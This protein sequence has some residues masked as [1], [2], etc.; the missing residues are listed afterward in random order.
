MN[1]G[2]LTASLGVDTIGLMQAEKQFKAFEMKANSSLARV[3]ASLRTVGT[4][5]KKFGSSASLYLTAPLLLVGGAAFK[6]SMDFEE[7]MSKIIGLVGVSKTQVEAWK[8]DIIAM[9]PALGKSP[10]ELADAMFFITSAGLRG[11]QALDVLNMSAKASAAGLGETK[12]V[13]DLVTS[14]MNAYGSAALSATKATDILV[15][16]VKEGKAEAGALTASLGT[17]L[18]VSSAMGV[19]FDQV[20]AAVAAMTRTGTNA[21]TASMQLRQI[22]VS[23]LKPMDGAKTALLNMGTSASGLRKKLREDGLIATLM[24]LKDVT[25]KYGEEAMSKVFPNV[26]ALSGVLDLVGKNAE[27]TEKIFKSLANATGLGAEAFKEATDTDMFKYNQMMASLK[28]TM[29]SLGK[30]LSTTFVPI[31]QTVAKKAQE[32]TE[33]FQNLTSTQQALLGKVI[34]FAAALGPVSKILGFLIGNVMPMLLTGVAKLIPLIRTL[35]MAMA[36]NPILAFATAILVVGTALVVLNNRMSESERIQA[37]LNDVRQSAVNHITDQKVQVEQL[38]RV[39]KNEAITIERRKAAIKKINEISPEYLKNITLETINTVAATR[40]KD[41]YLQAILKEAKIK[42]HQTDI[43]DLQK[44]YYKEIEQGSAKALNAQQKFEKFGRKFSDELVARVT[45]GMVKMNAGEAYGTAQSKRNWEARSKFILNSMKAHQDAIDELENPTNYK[46]SMEDILN[47]KLFSMGILDEPFR[48]GGSID[49][50]IPDLG[51][52]IDPKL[53][54]IIKGVNEQLRVHHVLGQQ[55]I[56]DYSELAE[57]NNTYTQALSTLARA[58]YGAASEQMMKYRNSIKAVREETEKRKPST[59]YLNSLKDTVYVMQDY[60]K[61]LQNVQDKLHAQEELQKVFGD[62]YNTNAQKADIYRDAIKRLTTIYGAN[63]VQVQMYI[64]LLKKL[65]EKTTEISEE[66]VALGQFLQSTFSQFGRVIADTLLS[67]DASMESFVTNMGNFLL[68]LIKRF[69]AAAV[70]ALALALAISLIPGMGFGMSLEMDKAAGLGA[71]FMKGF[72]KFA[73][74][75]ATGGQVPGGYPNDSYPAMLTSKERVLN[76]I[77][78]DNL[79]NKGGGDINI[80][81]KGV[82]EGE[83]LHYIVQQIERK[84][85]NSF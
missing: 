75:M 34:L 46:F 85:N 16:T 64:G 9:G 1:I 69:V 41:N 33:W 39:A 12:V 81:I 49:L 43:A 74:G 31:L 59:E 77:Q 67:A 26:R 14:A 80:N 56:K 32:L 2:S 38:Y 58:G 21:A 8:D 62:T 45:G 54:E 79:L 70:A 84:H 5:M 55:N 20:G 25:G 65:G 23:L 40:A 73:M 4:S 53:Q 42:G 3:N 28:T 57:N 82:V 83:D 7:S 36:S 22:M 15:G 13:A 63:S 66:T 50:S 71:N 78:F 61:V 6:M 51:N 29:V 48:I 47:P 76:P 72:G 10:K 68:S 18:P 44:Q 17:V 37:S 24:K 30:T 35:T 11:A 60:E 19:S 27:E 52:L